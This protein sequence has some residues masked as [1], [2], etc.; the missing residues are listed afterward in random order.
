[1]RFTVALSACFHMLGIEHDLSSAAKPHWEPSF[2]VKY[3]SVP[4]CLSLEKYHYSMLSK[5]LFHLSK[6]LVLGKRD[7]KAVMQ[8]LKAFKSQNTRHQ[9]KKMEILYLNYV[10]LLFFSF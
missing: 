2:H 4:H 7:E 5:I 6:D 9:R 8:S 1:M 10:N 3:C